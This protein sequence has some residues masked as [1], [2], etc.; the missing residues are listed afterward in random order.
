MGCLA[1]PYFFH[2]SLTV[3]TVELP[4]LPLLAIAKV[5]DWHCAKY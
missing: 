4:E 2:A 3:S 5:K 1:K